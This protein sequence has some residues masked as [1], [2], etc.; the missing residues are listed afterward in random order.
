MAARQGMTDRLTVDDMKGVFQKAKTNN[1]TVMQAEN[2][3]LS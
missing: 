3:T 2:W 1:D